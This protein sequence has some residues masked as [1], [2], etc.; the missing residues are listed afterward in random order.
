MRRVLGA[1]GA[2]IFALVAWTV[3]ANVISAAPGVLDGAQRLADKTCGPSCKPT[4]TE[5]TSSVLGKSFTFSYPEGRVIKV[6]CRRPYI[7]F[8]GFECAVER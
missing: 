3:Y 8:G 1:I 2:V 4:R 7:A 5:G 6:K